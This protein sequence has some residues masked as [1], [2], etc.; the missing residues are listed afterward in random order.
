MNISLLVGIFGVFGSDQIH[1]LLMN[2]MLGLCLDGL[3]FYYA[4]YSIAILIS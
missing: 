1:G 4:M 2:K 3:G